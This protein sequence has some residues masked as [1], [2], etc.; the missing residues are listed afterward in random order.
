MFY[1]PAAWVQNQS[2]TEKIHE[3]LNRHFPSDLYRD[4]DA[5]RA[6]LAFRELESIGEP[7]VAER[8]LGLKQ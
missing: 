2:N 4:G 6:T 1:V 7:V 5:D 3:I 8:L